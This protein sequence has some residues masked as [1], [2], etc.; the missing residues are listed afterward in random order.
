MSAPKSPRELDVLVR[1]VLPMLQK[2]A[3]H[4]A[5]Y[6]RKIPRDDFYSAGNESLHHAAVNFDPERKRDFERYARKYVVGAMQKCA[7]LGSRVHNAQIDAAQLES[8][9]DDDDLDDATLKARLTERWN[10]GLKGPEAGTKTA[11]QEMRLRMQLLMVSY[12]MTLDKQLTSEALLLE[13][14]ETAH[15]IETMNRT[16]AEFTPNHRRA[17]R[18]HRLERR[19]R[20]EIAGI[21]GCATKTVGR[22][23]K[24][25]E[26]KL[27]AAL[28][29]A[30][31]ESWEDVQQAWF[32]VMDA[33]DEPEK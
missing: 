24:T 7:R 22:W 4:F 20:E 17:Y 15:G 32:H 23:L 9:N 16:L 10:A 13:R 26:D 27:K 8:L 19:T 21:L 14:E 1:S 28:V 25:I 5:H 30:G 11:E 2:F 12:V 18:M 33:D 29:A 3:D 6:W 31:I